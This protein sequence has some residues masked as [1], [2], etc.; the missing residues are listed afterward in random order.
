MWV[1]GS[2]EGIEGK[3]L[4]WRGGTKECRGCGDNMMMSRAELPFHLY[5]LKTWL[6]GGATL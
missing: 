2:V 3:K 5:C 6:L 4:L 1:V